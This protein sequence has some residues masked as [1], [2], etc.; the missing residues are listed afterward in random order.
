MQFTA[1]SDYQQQ[2]QMQPEFVNTRSAGFQQKQKRREELRQNMSVTRTAGASTS[3]SPEQET[4]AKKFAE[5]A[6]IASVQDLRKM[7]ADGAYPN[8]KTQD[9]NYPAHIIF[10]RPDFNIDFFKML[11]GENH[12]HEVNINAQNN[13]GQTVLHLACQKESKELSQYLLSKGADPNIQ[14][15]TGNTCLHVL[16]SQS[17]VTAANES[18]MEQCLS[19]GG[20]IEIANNTGR[21]PNQL[22]SHVTHQRQF[23]QQKI[24]FDEGVIGGDVE[25]ALSWRNMNDLD[26]HC[27]CHCGSQIFYGSKV[28]GTCKGFLDVDMNVSPTTNTPVEHIYWAKVP[29]G[30]FQI[31]V[32]YFRN[33]PGIPTVSEYL[34][35][36]KIKEKIVFEKSGALNHEKEEHVIVTF[37]FDE[38]EKF[39]IVPNQDFVPVRNQQMQVPMQMPQ[40]QMNQ[41]MPMLYQQQQIPPQQRRARQEMQ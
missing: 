12:K 25:V 30:T 27:F 19:Y 37:K 26:L 9:G 8:L 23:M 24:D 21:L 31:H 6:K 17:T 41:Q 15:S 2:V 20:N 33:H 4:L 29:K 5:S 3:L 11:F 32:V 7:L 40:M 18:I 34:I 22:S 1:Q 10:A 16:A 36:M 28:C 13:K 38:G 35:V 14:D 39:T